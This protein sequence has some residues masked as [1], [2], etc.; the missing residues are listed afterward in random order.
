LLVS[1]LEVELDSMVQATIDCCA[2][3][4]PEGA[5]ESL[6]GRRSKRAFRQLSAAYLRGATEVETASVREVETLANEKRS[7]DEV[8]VIFD[9]WDAHGRLEVGGEEASCLPPLLLPGRLRILASGADE[10]QLEG[11]PFLLLR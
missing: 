11:V 8:S 5:S 2:R 1:D 9:L 10:L 6:E 4:R 3:H 7:L